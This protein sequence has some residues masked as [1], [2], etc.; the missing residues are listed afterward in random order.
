MDEIK[1]IRALKFL[2]D[3]GAISEEEFEFLKTK[4]I[5]E[6]VKKDKTVDTN[7]T[8]EITLE[9]STGIE[10]EEIPNFDGLEV[11]P[12]NTKSKSGTLKKI[13]IFFFFWR[14]LILR[15]CFSVMISRAYLGL[16]Y[17]LLA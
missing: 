11:S 15:V 16:Q 17:C 8:E 6:G 14:H 1:E 10:K 2:L 13:G 7:V 3:Q 12:K 4:L 5:I 9:T